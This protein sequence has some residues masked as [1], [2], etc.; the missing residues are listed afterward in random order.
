[1][2]NHSDYEIQKILDVRRNRDKIK[3]I[4]IIE[5]LISWKGYSSKYN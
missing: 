4:Y 3:H 1:M 5:V 2:S